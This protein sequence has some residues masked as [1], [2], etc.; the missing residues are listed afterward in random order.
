MKRLLLIVALALLAAACAS[1]TPESDPAST[2]PEISQTGS[3]APGSS[4]STAPPSRQD[5]LADT[6]TG[7]SGDNEKSPPEGPAAPDFTTVLA[8][9]ESYTLSEAVKPVYMIFWAEW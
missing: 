2:T 6:P 4:S 3:H 1:T 8:S 5:T 9:G 7:D